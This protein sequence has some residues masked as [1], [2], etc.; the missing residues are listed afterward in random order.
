MKDK[1]KKSETD[2][3]IDKMRND[4]TDSE[5]CKIIAKK[6]SEYIKENKQ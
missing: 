1:D 6:L 3:K 5:K 4:L 2:K